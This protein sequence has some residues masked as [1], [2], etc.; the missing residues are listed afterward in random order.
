MS[1]LTIQCNVILPEIVLEPLSNRIL[2]LINCGEINF[3]IE[4]V[5]S[6]NELK[7]YYN[8]LE[9]SLI[10]ETSFQRI[11]TK[12]LAG[13]H[14]KSLPLT[15]STG[16][17]YGSIQLI[18]KE[19]FYNPEGLSLENMRDSYLFG[20]SNNR[21]LTT[22]HPKQLIE[23]LIKNGINMFKTNQG[24]YNSNIH[25]PNKF[26]KISSKDIRFGRF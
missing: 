4:Y 14:H 7:K 13:Y 5:K 1:N 25:S 26:C 21:I 19:L 22:L 9:E 20:C 17:D 6:N 16:K 8:Y 12:K 24:I 3:Y 11:E 23:E 18:N 15:I 2:N 10:K